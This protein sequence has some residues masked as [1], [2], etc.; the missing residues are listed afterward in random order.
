VALIALILSHVALSVA[1][2]VRTGEWSWFGDVARPIIIVFLGWHA[3]RDRPWARWVLIAWVGLSA[4]TFL[5]GMVASSAVGFGLPVLLFAGMAVLYIWV[6][7]E[8]VV[9]AITASTSK[10]A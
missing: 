9:A 2:L 8:L 10:V 6:V 4:L 7:I 3:V 5:G 1:S